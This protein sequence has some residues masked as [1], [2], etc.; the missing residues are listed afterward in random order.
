MLS[1]IGRHR[2]DYID[3]EDEGL[4]MPY[5]F[6]S[7]SPVV[8][9][10]TGCVFWSVFFS[11]RAGVFQT[12]IVPRKA[13]PLYPKGGKSHMGAVGGER[14]TQ[15]DEEKRKKSESGREWKSRKSTK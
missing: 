3:T 13:L 14:G 1:I 6:G 10:T 12:R 9:I 2:R 7:A 8:I 5:S 11:S 15:R 4:S